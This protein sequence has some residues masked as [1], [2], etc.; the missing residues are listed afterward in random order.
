MLN[1][2]FI[3]I[4]KANIAIVAGNANREIINNLEDKGLRVIKTIKC[5]DVD[6]SIAY[7]PD[8]VMHPINYNTLIIA[9]NV[10]AYYKDK[11]KG[12]NL[13]LIKGEKELICK[14]PGDIAYNVGR[15][16]GNA[17]HNFSY[18]DELLKYYLL[19]EGLNLIDVKQGYTKCSISVVDQKSIITSD[20]PIYIKLN[21]LG[22]NV[23]NIKPGFIE[24]KGQSYGFIGGCSGNI[25]K[26]IIAFSGSLKDHPDREKIEKF[27]LSRNKKIEYL[28]KKAITDIGTIISL[29]CN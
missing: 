10:F 28:S 25:S 14:Y 7:H 27:I 24:L 20:I 23:L 2:P 1:N 13:N 5:E 4:N 12:L 29:Y 15:I 8:I 6:E 21:D 26:D 18:T 19:K 22:F 16:Y 17:I 3:P 9:P 11:F